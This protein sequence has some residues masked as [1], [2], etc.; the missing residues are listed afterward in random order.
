MEA[1]QNQIAQQSE[2]ALAARAWLESL[3]ADTATLDH[4]GV[5]AAMLCVRV[6]ENHV[7]DRSMNRLQTLLKRLLTKT[8]R[9]SQTSPSSISVL[10]APQR[11]LQETIAQVRSI[12]EV[13]EQ[14]GIE[15]STG[16]AHR[17][18]GESLLDT[19]ARAEAQLD[20]AA[21]RVEHR[22][23]ISI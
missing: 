9:L 4:A 19:W 23:G 8:D 6:R 21:Y 14:S 22:N 2:S 17:R 16:F 20:R 10:L 3:I 15:A 13:L 18:A 5:H 11:D 7:D 12:A 1:F